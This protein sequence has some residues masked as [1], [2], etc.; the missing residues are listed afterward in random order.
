MKKELDPKVD[1]RRG[2]LKW[3]SRVTNSGQYYQEIDGLRCLAIGVVL[4][5][6]VWGNWTNYT[7]TD[8]AG[9]ISFVD[10]M[11]SKATLHG[12][13]GVQ[14]FFII[15]GFI[16]SLPWTRYFLAAGK[17]ID[18]RDFYLRRL[19]RLEPPYIIIMLIYFVGLCLVGRL[20]FHENWGNLLASIFYVHNFVYSGGSVINMAAWSL[21]IEVQFYIL[22][23][24]IAMA[25]YRLSAKARHIL[26]LVLILAF[27]ASQQ[28][29]PTL[30]M[31][32]L[33]YGHFF[34]AGFVLS[35]A[36][37]TGGDFWRERSIFY[38]VL[39]LCGYILAFFIVPAHDFSFVGQLSYVFGLS[40]LFVCGFKGRLFSAFLRIPLVSIVGGMC[41]TIYLLHGRILSFSYAYILK[42]LELTGDFLTDSLILNFT[43][44]PLILFVS[45]FFFVLIERPCMNRDWPRKLRRKV[46]LY[47]KKSSRVHFRNTK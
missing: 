13:L 47:R 43:L 27:A 46:G 11:Y 34:I 5:A 10:S 38:D 32:I 28:L 12:K 8:Y 16:L 4:T 19:T 29:F 18:I 17:P 37:L 26:L 42:D 21:E 35:E 40:T 7:S 9:N 44:I 23:P 31:S 3:L 41:Y 45:A 22:A 36:F 14:L 2:L 1:S 33:Y 30:P 15:S 24:F 6:H 20:S 39:G 25:I